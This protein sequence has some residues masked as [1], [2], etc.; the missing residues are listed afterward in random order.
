M[1]IATCGC[2]DR[3]NST[4]VEVEFLIERN[5]KP[6]PIEVKAKRGTT[7]S[8]NTVLDKLNIEVG[9]KFGAGN[10]GVEGK[11]TTLPLFMTMF[12]S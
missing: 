7:T 6:V 1:R 4:S 3:C 12:V 8:L 9:Y 11:K 10:V 5:A 2:P